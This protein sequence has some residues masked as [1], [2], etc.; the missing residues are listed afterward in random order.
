MIELQTAIL[1]AGIIVFV[2]V[3]VVSYDRYRSGQ[4]D[5]LESQERV[6]ALR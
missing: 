6:E 2:V 3:L 4:N 5:K 1:I